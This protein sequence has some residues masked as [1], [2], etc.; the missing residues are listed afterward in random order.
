MTPRV[1]AVSV[2]SC[3]V[4]WGEVSVPVLDLSFLRVLVADAPGLEGLTLNVPVEMELHLGN[5]S[6]TAWMVKRATGENWVRLAFEKLTPSGS[7]HLRSFLSPKKI[8]E[9]L[10]EEW[11]DE[12][13][14]HFRGLNEASLWVEHDGG[15]L[16]AYLDHRD[17][18][19]QFV[20]RV[21]RDQPIQAGKIL[22]TD[23]IELAGLSA[24]LSFLPLSDREVYHRISECR[25]IV[26]NFRP[27]APSEYELKQ[28]LLKVISDYLYSTNY[29]VEI[30][31]VRSARVMT[32][33]PEN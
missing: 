29:R 25:D 19:A 1:K 23:Y 14:S 32:S 2:R 27:V 5:I 17:T 21:L 28:R 20:L 30:P 15:L 8:G 11:H 6:F 22:R 4:Q 3:H 31:P 9:S 33:Q 10:F 12:R 16:F 24:P 13:V 18:D 7:A 26:T